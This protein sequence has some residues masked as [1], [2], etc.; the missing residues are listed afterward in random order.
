MNLTY[1]IETKGTDE[2]EILDEFSEYIIENLQR[3]L[4]NKITQNKLNAYKD[5]FL[6]TTAIVWTFKKPTTVNMQFILDELLDNLIYYKT[7]NGIYT[8]KFND[9]INLSNTKN[10]IDSVVRFLDKGN[11]DFPGMHIFSKVF[12]EYSKNINRYWNHFV[13]IRLNRITISKVII[14]K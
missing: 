2:Y 5:M 9:K 7:K 11:E 13:L 12:N 4:A 3:D 6:E 14:I 8:I 1:R 10:S